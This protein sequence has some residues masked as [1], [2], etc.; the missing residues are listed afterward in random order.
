MTVLV[1]PSGVPRGPGE[2]TR[3]P[4]ACP[5]AGCLSSA[6][7]TLAACRSSKT[8]PLFRYF[9]K[10]GGALT[11]A[12]GASLSEDQRRN[13]ASVQITMQVQANGS[14]RT[15]PV[16]IQNMVGLPNLGVARVEVK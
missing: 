4:L 11:P 1:T 6:W 15:A 9:D 12:A 7:P 10:D 5:D 14:G 8:R 3:P 2:H 16:A 13:I